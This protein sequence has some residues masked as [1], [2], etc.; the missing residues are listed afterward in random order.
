[1]HGQVLGIGEAVD[2]PDENRDAA[3]QPEPEERDAVPADDIRAPA[4][5]QPDDALC[6]EERRERG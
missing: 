5:P 2:R 1:V 3:R 4:P 6:E